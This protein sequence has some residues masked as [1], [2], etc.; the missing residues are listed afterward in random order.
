MVSPVRDTPLFLRPGGRCCGRRVALLYGAGERFEC[1]H[2]YRLAYRSQQ[3]ALR[4]RGL[5]RHRKS[6]CDW[7]AARTCLRSSPTSQK[8]C[9]GELMIVC[10][11]LTTS[12]KNVGRLGWGNSLIDYAMDCRKMTLFRKVA[13]SYDRAPMDACGRSPS[14]AHAQPGLGAASAPAPRWHHFKTDPCPSSLV[15]ACTS[16]RNDDD[17]AVGC[18]GS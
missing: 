6:E 5:E 8:A 16:A 13:I 18:V 3:E 12:L 11:A 17:D 7:A 14:G 2:Y 10:V 9:I 1:R 15:V 4:H